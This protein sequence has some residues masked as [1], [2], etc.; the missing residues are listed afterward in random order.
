MNNGNH[1]RYLIVG[2]A[3]MIALGL[4]AL[5]TGSATFAEVAAFETALCGPALGALMGLARPE[6]REEGR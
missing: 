1:A 3:L 2:V 6:E 5:L 4:A